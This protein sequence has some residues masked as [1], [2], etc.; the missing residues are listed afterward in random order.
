MGLQLRL[1]LTVVVLVV[2][3]ALV[4]LLGTSAL[5][6]RVMVPF[7]SLASQAMNAT[8]GALLKHGDE[9]V[10]AVTKASVEDAVRNA[11]K[12][13]EM[14][15]E[16]EAAL[17]GR[18]GTQGAPAFALIVRPDG[19]VA[20]HAGTDPKL[21][22][23]LTGFPMFKEPATGLARD[24]VEILDNKPFHLAGAPV[25]DASGPGGGALLGVIMLGW[26]YDAAFVDKLS[27]TVGAPLLLMVK[28]QRLGHALAGV[29]DE[30][31]R[32]RGAGGVGEL[33]L[34]PLP[35]LL[36]LL[37]EHGRYTIQSR[38]M[39]FGND[40]SVTVLVAT[41]RNE[42]Y[43]ALAWAQAMVILGTLLITILQIVLIASTLRSVS[44]PIAVIVDHLSQVSQGNQV[45]ILPEAQLGGAFLRL[46]KQVNM[47][48]QQMPSTNRP[49]SG[50]SPIGGAP[51]L[52]T[53]SLPSANGGI[54]EV[55]N[56]SLAF[57]NPDSTLDSGLP[58]G[59]APLGGGLGTGHTPSK[60]FD[61]RP[62]SSGS[63]PSFSAPSSSTSGSAAVAKA[64]GEQSSGLAGL[65]DDGGADPLAAFRVPPP[66]AKSTPALAKP[67]PKPQP[68]PPQHELEPEDEPPPPQ[69]GMSPEATVMFQVPQELLNQ[70]ANP[71][72]S[73]LP[74][75]PVAAA[76]ADD[77]RTVVAQ[78]PQELLSAAAPKDGISNADEAH[79]RDVYDKFVETRV[80]CG[81]DTSDLTYDRFVAKLLKNRQQIVEKHKA[82]S[83]RFQVYVKEG[84]AA[85]R[86]LPVRE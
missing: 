2:A 29:S 37:M 75:R 3:G 8:E 58:M 65:F 27:Q 5:Y 82:K 6:E 7:E 15:P 67:A 51:A 43:R 63:G 55:S 64:G 49:G 74:Q 23:T 32:A 10:D 25:Y 50:L 4:L 16:A 61:A 18:A 44:K 81:E 77:A 34:K 9:A 41:D 22:A 13:G 73:N 28:N 11:V 60:P 69:A 62:A 38:P 48:L 54:K 1:W 31:L 59:G 47:I 42:A 53:P 72:T 78:V 80:Q 30:Q 20:A 12:K 35:P 17:L 57:G 36:P 79:Y 39:T 24:G 52:G 66:E 68:P 45:G 70:S 46:G 40:E 76:P 83:V 86:A 56:P 71:S 19:S 84:K 14:S 85:L 26:P 21:D 33:D